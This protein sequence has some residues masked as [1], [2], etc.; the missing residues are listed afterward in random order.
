MVRSVAL[1][2]LRRPLGVLGVGPSPGAN[3]VEIAVL[4]HQLAVLRWQLAWPRYTPADR[5]LLA[6]LARLLPG[7]VAG[8]PGDAVDTAALASRAGGP[9]LDLPAHRP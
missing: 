1:M 6:T 8:V 5:M 2:A 9:P 4:R 3:E 7:A